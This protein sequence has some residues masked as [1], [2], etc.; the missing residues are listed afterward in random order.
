MQSS[1]SCFRVYFKVQGTFPE[2]F[3]TIDQPEADSIDVQNLGKPLNYKSK[4]NT[5]ENFKVSDFRQSKSR[6]LHCLFLC[7]K[8]LS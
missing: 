1:K 3:N 8:I 2:N 7:P 5:K 4:K 6:L